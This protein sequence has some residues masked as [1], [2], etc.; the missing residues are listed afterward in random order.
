MGLSCSRVQK[1][2]LGSGRIVNNYFPRTREE[3]GRVMSSPT[4][5]FPP[6]LRSFRVLVHTLSSAGSFT[7]I[8]GYP[9]RENHRHY[10]HRA[11]SIYESSFSDN[12][13]GPFPIHAFPQLAL[14]ELRAFRIPSTT[15]FHHIP[16]AAVLSSSEIKQREP[17]EIARSHAAAAAAAQREQQPL[18]TRVYSAGIFLGAERAGIGIPPFLLVYPFPSYSREARYNGSFSLPLPARRVI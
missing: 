15:A 12:F 10:H 5:E 2:E 18:S 1:P 11:R 4:G 7:F 8:T 6:V 9:E 16:A 17:N 13:N 3:G 14:C